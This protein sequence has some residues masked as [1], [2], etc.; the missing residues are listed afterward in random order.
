MK[1][2]RFFGLLTALFALTA[3]LFMSACHRKDRSSSDAAP[4]FSATLVKS[5]DAIDLEKRIKAE[6]TRRY[7]RQYAGCLYTGPGIYIMPP[8]P[9]P[10]V[11]QQDSTTSGSGSADVTHSETN[12]QEK[13][14]DEGDLVKTDGLFIYLARGSHFFILK[15]NPAADMAIVSQI[16]L[17]EPISEL[18]SSGTGSLVSVITISYGSPFMTTASTM[19]VLTRTSP[20]TRLYTYDVTNAAAPVRTASVDFPGHLRGSRRINN[21]IYLV[22]DHTI[23]IPSPVYPWNYLQQGT[24]DQTAF[25]TA[26]AQA[27]DENIRNV[28]ALTLDQLLPAYTTTLYAGGVAGAPSTLP[29]VGYTDVF[30]PEFGNGMDLS[31]VFSIDVSS[32]TPAIASAGLLSSW[33]GIYMSQESL[34]LTSDNYWRWIEPMAGA[35]MPPA[36]PEPRTAVHKFSIAGTDG[37]PLYRG[38]GV[39]DGWLN[40]RFSMSEY[41]GHLRI[42]TTRGGWWGERVSNQL[43]ILAEN[44]GQLAETGKLTGIAPDE[45]I[46]SMRF[47]RDRG[48][49]VTFRRVDPLFTLDLS[50]TANPRL[51]GEIKVSGFA[52]YIHLLGADRLLTVG[53]SADSFG[54]TTGN[55]LQLFNVSDLTAPTLLAEHELGPGWSSALYDPHAFLYYEPFGVLTIPYYSYATL[56][57]GYTYT[58]GLMVFTVEASSISPRAGGIITSPT[59]TTNYGYSYNDTVDRSVIIGNTIYALAHRS[60]TAADATQL[61]FITTVALPESYNYYPYGPVSVGI[62][63]GTTISQ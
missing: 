55:K 38:S 28:A 60:V 31:L 30:I 9:G 41:Q 48:Y 47:D 14:V 25:N 15:A 57:S 6:L 52:T 51:A 56:A 45:R 27:R 43:A 12:V 20:V 44:D 49:M 32:Q 53:Q 24:Y 62:G 22:T 4:P 50:D 36:N 18:H 63:G 13:G 35:D 26:C 42:G 46:Y 2:L 33:G 54:R 59:I 37:K 10:V 39:V 5:V 3:L 34:Y 1:P 61:D 17:K 19:P 16:D 7:E 40:N 8:G 21:T 23:D 58:S 11:A 29:A